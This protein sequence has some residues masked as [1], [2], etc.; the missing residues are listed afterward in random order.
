[1]KVGSAAH[2]GY[3][4]SGGGEPSN[5]GARAVLCLL[6]CALALVALACDIP[7]TEPEPEPPEPEP[8]PEPPRAGFEAAGSS[9]SCPVPSFG[10]ASDGDST[11]ST[12]RSW[13]SWDA[14]VDLGTRVGD[15][16]FSESGYKLVVPCSWRYDRLG[17]DYDLLDRNDELVASVIADSF[18]WG[19]SLEIYDCAANLLASVKQESL[20]RAGLELE[21][22]DASGQLAAAADYE[23][24]PISGDV[25]TVRGVGG[26]RQDAVLSTATHAPYEL[27][28]T[29][30]SVV[31][32]A[33]TATAAGPGGDTRV[34]SSIVAYMVWKDRDDGKGDFAGVCQQIVIFFELAVFLFLFMLCSAVQLKREAQAKREQNLADSN[35]RAWAAAQREAREKREKIK[36]EAREKRE[37]T[38]EGALAAKRGEPSSG[39]GVTMNPAAAPELDMDMG[40]DDE[41]V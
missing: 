22:K 7:D 34:V 6:A 31:M 36:R 17:R 23:L 13:G 5:T 11:F 2:F 25:L 21:I 27:G 1:M 38:A 28:G 32:H 33:A 37:Q 20:T 39:T 26:D 19:W 16:G 30:W 10:S 41:N 4:T 24:H 29:E 8:E 12:K 3:N 15:D 18:A 14:T 9:D 40:G 35:M